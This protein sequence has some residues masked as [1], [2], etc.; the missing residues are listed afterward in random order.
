[1]MTIKFAR[2]AT[3]RRLR[4]VP[5]LNQQ[6]RCNKN[7]SNKRG[8]S[9]KWVLTLEAILR[10]WKCQELETQIFY[11]MLPVCLEDPKSKLKS[12]R[13]CLT[14][15]WWVKIKAQ[16]KSAS[17][18]RLGFV[19]FAK[20]KILRTRNS[21]EFATKML[22]QMRGTWQVTVDPFN[23]G[24]LNKNRLSHWNNQCH[25]RKIKNR[26]RDPRLTQTIIL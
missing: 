24:F 19:D 20:P 18:R 22:L 8:S 6:L 25:P 12:S 5:S 1:M 2:F 9:C 17:R 13:L 3:T 23:K 16:A 10:R 14:T 11:K 26:F 21:V 15:V 7:R 4:Q